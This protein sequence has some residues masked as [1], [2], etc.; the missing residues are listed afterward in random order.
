MNTDATFAEQKPTVVHLRM[1][2]FAFRVHNLHHHIQIGHAQTGVY[3]TWQRLITG[4]FLCD[5]MR[6]RFN[7]HLIEHFFVLFCFPSSVAEGCDSYRIIKLL[8]L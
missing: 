6:E 2:Y 7:F 8:M 5:A 3:I 1:C 4:C